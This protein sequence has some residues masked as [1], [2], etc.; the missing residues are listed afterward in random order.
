MEGQQLKETEMI[1]EMRRKKIL[2]NI[3]GH[4]AILIDLK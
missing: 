4:H 1:N 2:G 3:Y